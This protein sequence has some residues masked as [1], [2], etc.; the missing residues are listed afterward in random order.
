VAA[1]HLTGRVARGAAGTAAVRPGPTAGR[2]P[3]VATV[4]AGLPGQTTRPPGR[5][6]PAT[7]GNATPSDVTPNETHRNQTSRNA[8]IR[9]EANRSTVT[10]PG[11]GASG[12]M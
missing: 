3:A 9:N 8:A 1:S 4:H 11:A 5:A 12:A 7:R 10:S 2:P 6:S